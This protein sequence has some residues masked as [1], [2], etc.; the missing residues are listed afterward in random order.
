M[1]KIFPGEAL[2]F[3]FWLLFSDNCI[4]ENFLVKQ[5]LTMAPWGC[6]IHSNQPYTIVDGPRLRHPK[7]DLLRYHS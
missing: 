6:F 4:I 2:V 1:S 5:Q 7:E 3:S